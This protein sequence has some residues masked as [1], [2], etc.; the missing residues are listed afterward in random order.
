MS[1]S[2]LSERNK[3]LFIFSI[4]VI[5]LSTIKIGSATDLVDLPLS[6]SSKSANINATLT[7]INAG[8][9]YFIQEFIS[10]SGQTIKGRIVISGE[11]DSYNIYYNVASFFNNER[12]VYHGTNCIL[13]TFKNNWDQTLPGIKKPVTNLI[14]LMGPSLLYRFDHSSLVWKSVEDKN[15]RGTLMKGATT[16]INGRFRITYYYKKHFDDDFGIKHPSR[17]EFKGNDPYSTSISY[18]ENLILDIYLQNENHIDEF[19]NEVHPLPGIEC[20]HYLST[21]HP[22]FPELRTDYMHYT[23]YE[24]IKGSTTSRTFSE[25]H[26]SGNHNILR[27]K[28]NVLGVTTEAIYDYNLGVSFL[29]GKGGSCSILPADKNSP[30]IYP[31]G[32]FHL[33]NLFLV[34]AGYKYLGKFNLEHRSGLSV[35][36]WETF[37]YDF[38]FNG[39]KVDKAV[40]NQYFAESHDSEIFPGYTLVST[41][42]F[43]YKLDSSKETYALTDEITREYKNFE[44]AGFEDELHEVFTLK[45]CKYLTSDK[46]LTLAFKLQH[47][48][49]NLSQKLIY[50]VKQ[51]L[52]DFIVLSEKISPLR[53]DVVE[54]N[55]NDPQIVMEVT[56]LDSPNFQY[57]FNSKIISVSA[58]TFKKM[59]N[60]IK[61]NN[62]TEC[63][64]K[65]SKSQDGISV[66]IYRP[67][68]SSCGYLKDFDDLKE[69]TKIG[70]PCSVYHFPLNNL[71]RI[72]QEIPLDQIHNTFLQNI[73][74]IYWLLR[75]A[76]GYNLGSYKLIDVIDKTKSQYTSAGR[77]QSNI[78]VDAKLKSNDRFTV[79]VPDAKTLADC[80]RTC[81]NSE[82]FE[83]NTFSFCSNGECRVSS[84]LTD[85]SFN[86][87]HVEQDKSCSIH[88]LNVLND[89]SEVSHR[90]FKTQTSTAI[91]KDA[92]SCAEYCHASPD[93]F[94][95]Q[96]C[97]YRC[98]FG[99]VYTDSST[100]YDEVCSVY[101]PKV[102]DQYQ[103]T[104]NKIVSDVLYTE[105]NLNFEQCASLC[106]GWSDGDTGCKSFNYCPKSRTE[107]SCSLTKFSVKSS[108]TKT[109]EG[110]DCSNYELNE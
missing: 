66:V 12:L 14:L 87:S 90:K 63:L 95:F 85:D 3:M 80:Y 69:D 64:D 65:L 76:R 30:G 89:Y 84:L 101:L 103:K 40:I 44:K 109:T 2:L 27:I 110:G 82:Q 53:I 26:A 34:N 104:G 58:D 28:S 32:Y 105:M 50:E 97:N 20:P 68:D 94:S 54:H 37:K 18:K 16:E 74:E 42:I 19:A 72:H 10:A 38:N 102:S 13:F 5:L 86:E 29:F 35:D 52:M 7:D 78:R 93:C 47:E 60:E 33:D 91:D 51:N 4:E 83:C 41:K 57:I 17:I 62:E 15:I 24:Y 21:W 9:K 81:R 56:F 92:Y 46:K 79:T 45:D 22:R 11:K 31:Y 59:K 75:L 61:A 67:S 70:E 6:I 49:D 107:S 71:Q 88:A 99:G 55:F 77:F 36:A 106:H 73:G 8:N 96:Y 98:S 1:S 48:G 108:N 43:I 100:E 23:M 39:K 25:I